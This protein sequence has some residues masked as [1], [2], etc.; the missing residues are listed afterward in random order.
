MRKLSSK[1]RGFTLIELMVVGCCLLILL[2]ITLPALGQARSAARRAVCKNKLK[3]IGLAVH[4]Y[5]ETFYTFPPGWI[6]V[7]RAPTKSYGYGWQAMLLPY[8][9][10][11]SLYNRMTADR[12]PLPAA[13]ALLQTN[14]PGYR[15]PS[16]PTPDI[17]PLRSNY[18]T[19]NY[20]GN[21]GTGIG[22]GEELTPMATWL[23]PR[24][25]QNWPG[26]TALPHPQQTN[27]I[28]FANRATRI[29]DIID[30]TSNTF[31]VGERSAKS[32]SGIWAGVA[33]NHLT[34]DAVTN[35]SPGNML[36]TGFDSFSSYHN[37][38][39]HFVMCD[40]RAVFISDDID[41]KVYQHLSTRNGG[42]IVHIDF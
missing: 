7:H 21:A 6:T 13:N 9:E 37:G 35:C 39:V 10:Q 40:G 26:L 22:W 27:G 12:E 20:S 4:N 32:G 1:R 15:C 8:M 19:S 42:E 18:G 25:T 28:F 23:S 2:A 14:I 38:G 34:S 33:E 41:P 31:C 29:R 36:N 11:G 16:D 3:Q 30:G 5:H 24:R 17:N